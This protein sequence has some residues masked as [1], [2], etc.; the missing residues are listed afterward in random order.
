M[1]SSLSSATIKHVATTVALV[2]QEPVK[3]Q[4]LIYKRP[5]YKSCDLENYVIYTLSY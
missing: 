3:V 5:I 4:M 1:S 2:V